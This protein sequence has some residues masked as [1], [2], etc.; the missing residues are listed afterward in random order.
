V[1]LLAVL[2]SYF[3]RWLMYDCRDNGLLIVICVNSN[4]V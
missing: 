2:F 3:P 1:T 4:D